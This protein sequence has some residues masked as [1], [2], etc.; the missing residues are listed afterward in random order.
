MKNSNGKPG[1]RI[2]IDTH[3]CNL[4]PA[5]VDKMESDLDSLGRQVADFPVAEVQILV[6]HNARSNDYSVKTSLILPG[7]TLVGN[8]RDA[9]VHV[10][11]QNCLQSLEENVRGYKERLDRTSERQK[12]EKGTHQDLLPSV[13]PD[14]VE[15]AEAIA[16]DDYSAFRTAT[17]GYEDAVRQRA[18]RW[19]DA[20]P[21]W[22]PASARRPRGSTTWSKRC[23]ST[24]SRPASIGRAKSASATGW[25]A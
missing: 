4:S 16:A 8:G 7:S 2:R 6:E 9:A 5:V 12:Q 23:S 13:D 17:F 22:P 20:T 3:Q 24:P 21:K 11:F 18:G 19:I 14:P 25:R 15:L 1:L 10:A